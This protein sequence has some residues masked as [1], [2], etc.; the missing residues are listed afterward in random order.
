MAVQETGVS[1]YGLSYVEH[2]ERDFRDLD[3]GVQAAK[4]HRLLLKT[5]DDDARARI[6][7]WFLRS[8]DVR[9]QAAARH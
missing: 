1:Y 5:T 7:R 2:A 8:A 3:I 9:R 4:G 6:V